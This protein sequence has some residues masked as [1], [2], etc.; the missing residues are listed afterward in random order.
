MPSFPEKVSVKVLD[1]SDE[2]VFEASARC[3][4][5]GDSSEVAVK[6]LYLRLLLT[7]HS[8]SLALRAGE[9]MAKK[10]EGASW[11]L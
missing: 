3:L 1:R 9:Y 5:H 8:S 4:C 6:I 7:C 10:A 11:L 2:A